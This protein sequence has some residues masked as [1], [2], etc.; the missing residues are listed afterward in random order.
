MDLVET[1]LAR[2]EVERAERAAAR[3]IV[4]TAPWRR[5]SAE[6]LLGQASVRL[7]QGRVQDA[8][9]IVEA[10]A[11]ALPELGSN[12]TAVY[13]ALADC[14]IADP[15]PSTATLDLIAH[16]QNE[17]DDQRYE[18]EVATAIVALRHSIGGCVGNCAAVSAIVEKWDKKGQHFESVKRRA[19]LALAAAEHA[20]SDANMQIRSALRAV[21]AANQTWYLRVF[22]RPFAAMT[23]DLVTD[24]GML[25]WFAKCSRSIPTYG[26]DLVS[27][28][29]PW[30]VARSGPSSFRRSQHSATRKQSRSYEK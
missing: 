19:L 16:L 22:L 18:A 30:R 29:Y 24:A 13:L 23:G 10:V 1:L 9:T 4:N 28:R 5:P 2:R 12:R 6:A 27:P 7:H 15:Q 25:R 11:S 21:V 14:F 17:A 20:T 8:R 3:G 26:A